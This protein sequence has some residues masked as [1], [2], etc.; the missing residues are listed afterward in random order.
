MGLPLIRASAS[1]GFSFLLLMYVAHVWMDYFWLTLMGLAG[2]GSVKILKSKGYGVLLI[3]LGA[4]L[5]LFAMNIS[6][7]IFLNLDFLP[8]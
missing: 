1:M 8:F 4:V 6:L 3:I 5:I 2:E 7:E